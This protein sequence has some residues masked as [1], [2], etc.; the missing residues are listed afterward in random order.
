MRLQP[1]QG[2]REVEQRRARKRNRKEGAIDIK[3][4]ERLEMRGH[5]SSSEPR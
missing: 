3:L 2:E 5:M 4:R 1:D